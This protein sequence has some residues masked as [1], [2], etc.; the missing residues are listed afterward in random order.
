MNNQLPNLNTNI[1]MPNPVTAAEMNN[2]SISAIDTVGNKLID[3]GIDIYSDEQKQ[4]AISQAYKD[5]SEGKYGTVSGITGAN[6]E[7]NKIMN[8]IAPSIMVSQVGSQLENLYKTMS[9]DPNF[10]PATATQKYA[11]G[12]KGIIDAYTHD[13]VPDEWKSQVSLTMHKQ[14]M[15][16]GIEMNSTV[17]QRITNQQ[18]S[19]SLASKDEL[20][21]QITQASSIGN[22][23]IANDLHAQYNNIVDQGILANKFTPLQ[24]NAMK[25]EAGD[26]IKL[27]SAIRSGKAITDDP[28]LESRRLSL[29]SQQQRSIE[30]SQIQ[31]HYDFSRLITGTVAGDGTS[32][33]AQMTDE[34]YIQYN[35]AKTGANYLAIAKNSPDR[36]KVF[37]SAG[38]RSLEPAVQGMVKSQFD[39]H[40]AKLSSNPDIALN[41]GDSNL[42]QIGN[43]MTAGNVPLSGISKTQRFIALN[44]QMQVDPIGAIK[45]IQ[46][47]GGNYTPFILSKMKVNNGQSLAIAGA[48]DD[49]SYLSGLTNKDAKGFTTKELTNGAKA[50]QSISSTMP[51]TQQAISQYMNVKKAGNSSASYD[52]IFHSRF[53][54][55]SMGSSKFVVYKEDAGVLSHPANVKYL[56]ASI[57]NKYSLPADKITDAIKEHGLQLSPAGDAYYVVNSKGEIVAGVPRSALSKLHEATGFEKIKD[58]LGVNGL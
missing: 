39:N 1:Q 11:V 8:N 26:E 54:T 9:Q 34:Q 40:V 15:Q 18:T 29:Y 48:V 50:I 32:P 17:L 33:P 6:K 4:G 57:A 30:Q 37:N 24:G 51:E 46:Q 49:Q 5:A 25:K 12:A 45:R 21:K 56:A 58:T 53:D 44:N 47:E 36:E 35:Q 19:A 52:D 2:K 55:V 28:S 10:D 31:N 13:S 3:K 16:Y 22:T 41:L 38:F 43:I 20:F 23:G 14:A 7:Y 27:Q 42:Q